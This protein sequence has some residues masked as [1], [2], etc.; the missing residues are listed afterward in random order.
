MVIE[1]YWGRAPSGCCG[2]TATRNVIT[3]NG[4]QDGWAGWDEIGV[5]GLSVGHVIAH[6]LATEGVADACGWR[7]S[8]NSNCPTSIV[9]R[10]PC[11]TS[12]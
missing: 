7:T 8:T 3:V 9:S 11:W 10:R 1:E 12:G 6:T 5:V 2:S 4:A